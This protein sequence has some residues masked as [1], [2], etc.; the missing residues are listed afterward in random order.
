VQPGAATPIIHQSAGVANWEVER[1]PDLSR[2]LTATASWLGLSSP[3]Y[4]HCHISI[5]LAPFVLLCRAT[6]WPLFP[7]EFT[8][9][10]LQ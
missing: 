6:S 9:E 10:C 2:L 3:K 5:A 1:A 4:L 7:I 8:M